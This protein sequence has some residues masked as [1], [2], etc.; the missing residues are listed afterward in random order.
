MIRKILMRFT[1]VLPLL[2]VTCVFVAGC[3]ANRPASEPTL[4][5]QVAGAY[6]ITR[7]GDVDELKF[8]YNMQSGGR[9]VVRTW[10]WEPKAKRVT[11]EGLGPENEHVLMRFHPFE[12]NDDSEE[13]LK[14]INHWFIHDRY[15]LLFPFHLVWD[16]TVILTEKGDHPLP[17]GDG[18]ARL[19]EAAF[20]ESNTYLPGESY[21]LYIGDD[22]RILQWEHRRD[23]A[24]SYNAMKCETITDAGLIGVCTEYIRPDSDFRIW[25]SEVAGE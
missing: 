2:F 22:N 13:S 14:H 11:F 24:V 20:T 5:E 15:L 10:T 6:G 16:D 12:V 8:T 23:E 19:L 7:W 18:S 1:V 17:I 25:Y 9:R 21:N 3:A 4:A